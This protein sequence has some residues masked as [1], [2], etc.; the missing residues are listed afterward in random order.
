MECLFII[1]SKQF[2]DKK[3]FQNI[4]KCIEKAVKSDISVGY[5]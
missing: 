3:G 2:R 4:T 5:C 1:T